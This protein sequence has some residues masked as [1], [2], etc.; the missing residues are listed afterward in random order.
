MILAPLCNPTLGHQSRK[1]DEAREKGERRIK[2]S[3]SVKP[4]GS[5]VDEYRHSFFT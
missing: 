2:S 3:I 1:E 5:D 4:S